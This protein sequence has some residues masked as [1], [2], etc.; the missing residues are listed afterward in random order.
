MSVFQLLACDVALG[1]DILNV[2][3]RHEFTP[4]TYPEMLVLRFIHGETSVTNVF[5][6]GYVDRAEGEEKK[7]LS[8]TYGDALMKKLFPG[9]AVRLPCGDN[10][11]T[12][13]PKPV[14]A[15][16][17]VLAS[18][19]SGDGVRDYAPTPEPSFVPQAGAAVAV[20]PEILDAPKEAPPAPEYTP[21]V[22]DPAADAKA[23][24]K[25]GPVPV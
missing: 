3:A 17:P 23:P 4:V 9:A 16:A 6:V 25:R 20:M 1:G 21:P 7:R 2:V 14:P 8:E 12:P 15:P 10:R 18:S 11:Y 13:H 5:D 24:G 22:V 19:A